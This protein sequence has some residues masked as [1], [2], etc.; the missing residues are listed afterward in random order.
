[1]YV[2]R[3]TQFGRGSGYIIMLTRFERGSVY[4]IILI[5]LTR[6]TACPH[7]MRLLHKEEDCV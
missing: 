2:V 5:L 1:M 6:L 7:H 3:L 4:V